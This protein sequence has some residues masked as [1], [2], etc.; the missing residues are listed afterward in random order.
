MQTLDLAA[1]GNCA[2]ASLID[3]GGRHVWF[4][5]PR[6][7]GDPVFSALVNGDDPQHGFMDVVVC[8]AIET[9]QRY[10]PNTAVLETTITDRHGGQVRIIDF[11]PRARRFDRSFHPPMLVR[12]IEPVTKHVRLKV[13]VRPHF[14][15]GATAPSI[16]FGSNH[17]R[18]GG[19]QMALRV[20]AD[21]AIAYILEETEF[22]LD[23]AINLF[24]GPDESV[25]EAPDSLAQS[26]LSA[27]IE[28]WRVWV[29]GLSIPFEWQQEVIRSAITLKLCSCEDTG[30]IVAALTTS[31]PEAPHTARNWDYRFCWL[32]DAFFTV[33]AL[34]RLGAT[35]TMENFIR[36]VIDAVLREN[37]I[38]IAPLY[39]I[40]PGM[41][42]E[43]RLAPSLAGYQG[44]GPVRIGNAAVSQIQNDVYG[45]IILT[46]AQM[47]WDTRLTYRGLARL[48]Q[49]LRGMGDFAARYALTVDAGPWEYRGRSNIHT[50]SAAMCWAAL[51]RLARIAERVGETAEAATWAAQANKLRTEILKRATTPEGWLSGVLD[52][53]VTD[54]TCLLLAEIGFLPADDPRIGKTLDI[55]AKRLM[56]DGFVMRYDEADDFG[57]PE[58]AFLVCTFWYV[59]ALAFA[60]R[61]D[62]AREI[63][64]NALSVRNAMGLLSEDV[65]TGPRELWGNFPQA[66]SHVGLVHSAA[67]L[68]RGWEEALWRAS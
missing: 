38:A 55:I 46:A 65:L 49:Q 13:R 19:G 59:D 12:R 24:I 6:L 17:V 32:R 25:P 3:R 48:Y 33:G 41:S 66:Y 47:F 44:M 10:L 58:T 21:M 23:R 45:S 50:Y 18:Y 2:I 62:E 34:N 36:F 9:N 61:R 37:D 68:S 7:D 63:F 52:A 57:R 60:G 53:P 20:T 67:R 29:R 16:S 11:A 64:K 28:D 30:A 26:F 8:E 1:I 15:Y 35:R 51:N 43:E 54:A 14:N 42:S 22:A 27:T 4:C 56:R 31:I 40:S 39:P 5:F